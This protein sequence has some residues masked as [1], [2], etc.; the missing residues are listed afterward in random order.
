MAVADQAI[1]RG[2]APYAASETCQ[3]PP[4]LSRPSPLPSPVLQHSLFL[5]LH[6][7]RSDLLS[8]RTPTNMQGVNE[9]LVE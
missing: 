4:S 1:P 5:S 8:R 2:S 3:I 9:F 7:S 6:L